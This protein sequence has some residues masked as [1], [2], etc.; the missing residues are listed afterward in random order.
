MSDY[1]VLNQIVAG[2]TSAVGATAAIAGLWRPRRSWEPDLEGLARAP[3][4]VG[5]LVALAAIVLLYVSTR[6]GDHET[7]AVVCLIVAVSACVL[8]LAIYIVL[9]EFVMIEAERAVNGVVVEERIIGGL[10]LTKKA[11]DARHGGLSR[12]VVFKMLGFSRDEMWPP[13][14]RGVAKVATVIAY[15]AFVPAGTI[16]VAAAGVALAGR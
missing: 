6:D 16:A 10:W 3:E 11:R 14:S 1:G 9:L 15:L 5:S 12:P 2:A 8:A 4:R 13:L 7:V